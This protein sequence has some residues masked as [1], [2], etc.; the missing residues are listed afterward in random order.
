MLS[1]SVVSD[2]ATLWTGSLQAPLS[3]GFSRQENW[4]GLSFLSPGR[5][6][7]PGIEPVSLTPA[8][9]AGG[10]FTISTTWEDL[11]GYWPLARTCPI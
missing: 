10:F 4:S 2:S 6:P 3:V 5:L 9:L 11:L 7:G 1:H 8:A